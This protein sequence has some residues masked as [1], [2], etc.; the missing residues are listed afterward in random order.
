MENKQVKKVVGGVNR[1]TQIDLKTIDSEVAKL[2]G[3]ATQTPI[4]MKELWD[5]VQSLKATAKSWEIV[6]LNKSGTSYP[7]DS[8]YKGWNWIILSGSFSCNGSY[9]GNKGSFVIDKSYNS[10][11]GNMRS[12]DSAPYLNFSSS[13]SNNGSAIYSDTT[14]SSTPITVLFYK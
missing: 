13:Y 1:S 9:S 7:F 12:N 14:K 4:G 2:S 11:S 8:K 3:R 6:T 5:E 10:I